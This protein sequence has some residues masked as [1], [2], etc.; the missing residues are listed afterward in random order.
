MDG[1]QMSPSHN[2][3]GCLFSFFV[4]LGEM[5]FSALEKA[6]DSYGVFQI[7]L[8]IQKP[9]PLYQNYRLFYRE[10]NAKYPHTK[11]INIW[12][13]FFISISCNCLGIL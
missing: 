1:F 8:G 10:L 3:H 5:E 4:N 9:E 2:S 6:S 11:S 12:Q 13:E 7:T